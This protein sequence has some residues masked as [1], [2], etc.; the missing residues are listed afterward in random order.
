MRVKLLLL[1][2]PAMLFAGG[3]NLIP[4]PDFQDNFA[5]W[6][7]NSSALTL[8]SDAAGEAYL[9][10]RR[11]PAQPL[12]RLIAV[13]PGLTPEELRDHRFTLSFQARVSSLQGVVTVKIRQID[14][15]GRSLGY[16][17]LRF[18][19]YDTAPDWQNLSRE[20]RMNPKTTK[21]GLY[22]DFSYL[23]ENDQFCLRALS[24]TRTANTPPEAAN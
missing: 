21:I 19:Q 9:S 1:L 8:Q 23:G 12:Q 14:A 13:L 24:L 18:C 16:H 7:K 11:D 3:K 17:T 4:N 15:D 20:Y 6:W 5:G 22:L 10:C 2:L